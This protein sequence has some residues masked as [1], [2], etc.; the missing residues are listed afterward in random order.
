MTK[1][2]INQIFNC[3]FL[4]FFCI[5]TYN[6][7][8]LSGVYKGSI[9]SLA[10]FKNITAYNIHHRLSW[11]SSKKLCACVWL[12]WVFVAADSF[13]SCGVQASQCGG[14]PCCRAWALG[15]V[16]S[17]DVVHRPRCPMHVGSQ[18][19]NQ[20]LDVSPALAEGFLTSRPPGKSQNF[21][22]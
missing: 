17:K 4:Q 21:T 5:I 13:F 2:L 7:N 19:L 1:K 18:L 3:D 15:H 9:L 6:L 10:I 14:Y 22:F 8:T 16:G 11:Y 20:G 12:C